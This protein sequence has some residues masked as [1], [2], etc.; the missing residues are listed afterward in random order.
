MFTLEADGRLIIRLP[1]FVIE[2]NE[3]FQQIAPRLCEAGLKVV[4]ID[5][6]A[7]THINGGGVKLLVDLGE[8]CKRLNLEYCL[9]K[10]EPIQKVLSVFN[11]RD[12][13]EL[14]TA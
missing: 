8:E 7:V 1:R 5:G 14:F 6:S 11:S 10:S 9:R 3:L 12:C 2:D 4:I 13:M